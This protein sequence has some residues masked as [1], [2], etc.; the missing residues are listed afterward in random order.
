MTFSRKCS[1]IVL[2]TANARN[3]KAQSGQKAADPV[4]DRAGE[5]APEAQGAAANQNSPTKRR[6]DEELDELARLRAYGMTLAARVSEATPSPGDD[7]IE[8]LSALCLAFAR[9][10]RAVRQLIAM[11]QEMLG[12]RPPRG[13]QPA[14]AGMGARAEAIDRKDKARRRDGHD[15]ADPDDYDDLDDPD[16][17]EQ[18]RNYDEAA[19]DRRITDELDRIADRRRAMAEAAANQAGGAAAG[20]AQP[21]SQHNQTAAPAHPSSSSRGPP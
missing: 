21:V 1:Y 20:V 11:E 5:A 17:I 19:L 4:S 8:D 14:L 18:M 10:S 12:L 16:Y 15:L 2:L 7:A 3:R 9:V 13:V 6:V